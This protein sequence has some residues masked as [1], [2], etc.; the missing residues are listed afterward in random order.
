M[1]VLSLS[2]CRFSIFS[3]TKLNYF[4]FIPFTLL[5]FIDFTLLLNCL[6][7]SLKTSFLELFLILISSNV[8]E[9]VELNK[10]THYVHWGCLKGVTA[11]S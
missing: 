6:Y 5:D 8:K 2:Y 7:F 4:S 3:D 11:G 9:E 1:V 10:N